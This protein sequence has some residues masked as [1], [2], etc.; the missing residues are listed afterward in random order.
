MELNVVSYKSFKIRVSKKF[1]QEGPSIKNAHKFCK[2][3][4]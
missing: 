4:I 2:V 1:S 3:F